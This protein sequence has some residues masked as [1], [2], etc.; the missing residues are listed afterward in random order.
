MGHS[1]R[2][3]PRILELLEHLQGLGLQLGGGLALNRKRY[4]ARGQRELGHLAAQLGDDALGG[5]RA[6]AGQSGQKSSVAAFDGLGDFVKWLHEAFERLHESHSWH[7]GERLEEFAV[8]RVQ[9][10]YELRREVSAA[11]SAVNIIDSI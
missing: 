11:Q 7:R 6:D 5:L 3:G 9:E 8:E 1:L 2:L 10:P 4:I